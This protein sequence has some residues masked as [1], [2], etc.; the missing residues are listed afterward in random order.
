MKHFPPHLREP[1]LVDEDHHRELFMDSVLAYV[2]Y[3]IGC[4]QSNG[5]YFYRGCVE[6]LPFDSKQILAGRI[7]RFITQESKPSKFKYF[8]SFFVEM[9]SDYI[10]RANEI[11][12]Y[13]DEES[14]LLNVVIA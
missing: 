10:R 11:L 1:L 5:R 9:P 4:A 8:M 13:C 12:R 14:K 2:K 7:I 6:E 3:G